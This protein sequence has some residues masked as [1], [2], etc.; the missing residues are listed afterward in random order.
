[1][2]P[3]KPVIVCACLSLSIS[4]VSFADEK[5]F[6][7]DILD[8]GEFDLEFGVN[9]QSESRDVLSN[10]DIGHQSSHLTSESITARYG[11]G[12]DWQIGLMAP[13][14]SQSV[15]RTNYTHPAIQFKDTS[16]QGSV[17]PSL[18]AK[19]GIIENRSSPWSLSTTL[20]VSPDTSNKSATEYE[21]VVALGYKSSDSL[22][23]YSE[24]TGGVYEQDSNAD[25]LN[26][27]FGGYKD[28][29]SCITLVPHIGFTEFSSTNTSNSF[30]QYDLGLASHIQI[31]PNTYLIPVANYFSN[32]SVDSR[33]SSFHASS[34]N[35]T[36][37]TLSLYHLF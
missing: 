22:R 3:L 24:L 26:I 4:S 31:I 34:S 13:Y 1:M 21:G 33:N 36:S 16:N 37:I 2:N 11:L 35:G 25:R 18:F 6:P 5:L 27:S 10:N 8:K 17:N 30:S 14:N 20:L 23:Y 32:S 29:S 28:I 9:H 12:N 15:T 19:Y 7:T